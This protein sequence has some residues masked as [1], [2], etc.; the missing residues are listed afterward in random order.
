MDATAL[1]QA[2]SSIFIR[3]SL[4]RDH[5]IRHLIILLVRGNPEHRR[6]HA[7]F[8]G[9][10]EWPVDLSCRSHLSAHNTPATESELTLFLDQSFRSARLAVLEREK[11]NECR[12]S[13]LAIKECTFSSM[14]TLQAS[15]RR[16]A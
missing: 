5:R 6:L 15:Q 2:M 7:K 9:G 13:S 14:R 16:D 10:G 8:A 4:P 1:A 3:C 12:C 11:F